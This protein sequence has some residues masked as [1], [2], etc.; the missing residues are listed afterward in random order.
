[1]ATE[2]GKFTLD[3][4]LLLSLSGLALPA[5]KLSWAFLQDLTAPVTTREGKAAL[6][7]TECFWHYL[8]MLVPR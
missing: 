2:P 1:M 5:A 6:D 4:Q 8:E 3:L 7:T